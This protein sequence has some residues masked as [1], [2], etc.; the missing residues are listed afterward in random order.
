MNRSAMFA[1]AIRASKA[2][3]GGIYQVVCA[4]IV[5]ALET[6]ALR[7]IPEDQ[8]EELVTNALRASYASLKDAFRGGI[9][10]NAAIPLLVMD[11]RTQADRLYR[12]ELD[13]RHAASMAEI[14][15][16]EA[17]I[18]KVDRD[19][20]SYL[21]GGLAFDAGG[22]L[23]EDP[24]EWFA[25]GYNDRKKA[26]EDKAANEATAKAAAE[27][28]KLEAEAA[29]MRAEAEGATAAPPP[30]KPTAPATAPRGPRPPKG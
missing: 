29:A 4:A 21:D 12:A 24:E 19:Q 30:A 2:V 26:V 17:D 25:L 23:G 22:E 7:G 1:I 11:L 6:G 27:E 9:D 28:A 13:A 16:K 3:L 18:E 5:L 15:Q 14:A 8:W 20:R 10:M